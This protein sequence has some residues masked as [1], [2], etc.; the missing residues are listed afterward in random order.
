M[1]DNCFVVDILVEV[2]SLDMGDILVVVGD[3]LVADYDFR[4]ERDGFG[5][6][7]DQPGCNI[8][9]LAVD[10]EKLPVVQMDPAMEETVLHS[11]FLALDMVPQLK[12]L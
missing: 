6:S 10:F 3:I 7:M 4:S 5:L 11:S 8:V 1:V 9:A 2:D 12:Y